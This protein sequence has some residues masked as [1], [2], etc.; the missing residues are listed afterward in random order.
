MFKVKVTRSC[1]ASDRCWP[2][3]RETNVLEIPILVGRLPITPCAINNA[4]QFQGRRPKV[5]VT[6]STDAKTGSASYFSKEKAYELLTWYT[7]GERIPVSPTSTR[8]GQGP[9]VTWSVCQLLGH[10][11]RTKFERRL[12]T[13]GQ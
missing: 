6:R 7:Y 5:N 11:L 4:H 12:P 1:D 10:M 9:E 3:N 13:H 8:Q 2:I